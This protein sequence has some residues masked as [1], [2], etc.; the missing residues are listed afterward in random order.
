MFAEYL[1]WGG[2]RPRPAAEPRDRMAMVGRLLRS[3]AAGTTTEFQYLPVQALQLFD[4]LGIPTPGLTTDWDDF[5]VVHTFGSMLYKQADGSPHPLTAPTDPKKSWSQYIAGDLTTGHSATFDPTGG[6]S[7]TDTWEAP[8]LSMRYYLIQF[9]GSWKQA[10]PD[11]TVTLSNT[12][13]P[14][15]IAHLYMVSQDNSDIGLSIGDVASDASFSTARSSTKFAGSGKNLLIVLVNTRAVWPYDKSSR[16]TLKVQPIVS[17]PPPPPP[18]GNG[19]L[20]FMTGPPVFNCPTSFGSTVRADLDFNTRDTVPKVPV[21]WNGD[22]F[23]VATAPNQTV[24]WS[25]GVHTMAITGTVPGWATAMSNGSMSPLA[26]AS[27][28]VQVTSQFDQTRYEF[29]FQ[30]QNLTCKWLSYGALSCG[31][32]IPTF[33]AS[34]GSYMTNVNV[35]RNGLSFTAN[36]S[37]TGFPEG[38]MPARFVFSLNRDIIP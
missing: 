20:I 31:V 19:T 6:N 3:R 13:G 33:S 36:N 35:T 26:G 2:R 11:V 8:D 12:A 25:S 22:T 28:K 32:P 18:V 4:S 7:Y 15:A 14:T 37:L 23:A 30:L 16:L 29:N 9:T 10:T 24:Q 1:M 17:S 5:C 27:A 34:P 38:S 21:Q